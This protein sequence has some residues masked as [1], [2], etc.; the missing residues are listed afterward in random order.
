MV[1]LNLPFALPTDNGDICYEVVFR[2]IRHPRLELK[3]GSLFVIAPF[4]YKKSAEFVKKYSAWVIKKTTELRAREERARGKEL[5]LRKRGDFESL[6]MKFIGMYSSQI[7]FPVNRVTFRKMKSRWGSCS[8]T[9]NITINSRLSMLPDDMIRYIT[10]HE[11]LH[12][13]IRNHKK[14]FY[15]QVRAE[16]PDYKIIEKELNEYWL[17]IRAAA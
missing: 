1:Q 17:A 12:R 8:S 13:K 2:K 11:V 5:K 6:V 3:S 15:K 10:H 7:G 4:G 16:F 14:E 9:G